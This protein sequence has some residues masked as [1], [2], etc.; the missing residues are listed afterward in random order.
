MKMFFRSIVLRVI[1][2]LGSDIHDVHTGQR[3]GRALLIPWRGR[4]L[5]LGDGLALVA[6]FH[7]QSRF[8]WWKR[9]L[10]FTRH[11]EPDFPHE[12]GA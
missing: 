11:P 2:W 5:V 9:E 1:H 6:Q 8:T 10:G 4:V 12:P 3:I 7:P